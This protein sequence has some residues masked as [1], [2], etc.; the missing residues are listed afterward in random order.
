MKKL[1]VILSVIFLATGCNIVNLSSKN[2]DEVVE[3][4]VKK[5]NHLK[6]S[7]FEGYSYY[8]PRGLT[9]INKDDYNAVLK[10]NYD[11]YYYLY[12]DVVSYYHNAKKEYKVDNNAFYS[13]EIK[14]DKKFGY[15]E[16]NKQEEGYFIEAMFNYIKVEAYVGEKELNDVLT[17]ICTIIS[18]IKY[19]RNVLSTTIGENILDYKEENFDI[20]NTKKNTDNFLDYVKEYEKIED[21]EIDEDNLKIE[22]GE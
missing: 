22:E 17:D 12:V 7:N 2:I 18:S 10:D 14:Y 19:N 9:F 3:L 20:F 15:L 21:E 5:S 1:F 6:N 13:K 8:I 11:N 16:I 4:I